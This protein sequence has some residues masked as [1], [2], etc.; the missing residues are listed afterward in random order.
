MRR[1]FGSASF[2]F[3]LGLSLLLLAGCGGSA[4]TRSGGSAA[5]GGKGPVTLTFGTWGGAAEDQQLQAL[6]RQVNEEHKGEFQIVEQNTPANYDDKLKTQLAGGTAPD[7]FYVSDGLVETFAREG[8]LLDLTPYLEKYKSRYVEADLSAYYPASL[9]HVKVGGKVYALPWVAQPVVMYYN[10]ELFRQAGLPEPQ[11]GWTWDQF[12]QDAKKLTDPARNQYGYIQANGWPPVEMYLWAYGGD[13][14]DPSLSRSTIDS[15]QALKGLQLMERMVK[16]GVTPPLS[17][18]ANVD[19]ED[20][21]RQGRVAMFAG[22]AADGNYQTHGFTAK[23]AELPRGTQPASFLYVADM[24]INAKAKDPDLAFRAMMALLEKIDHWKVLPPI[25]TYA[26]DLQSIQVPDAPGGHTPAD[27]V[28]PIL[29]SMEYARTPQQ[30]RDMTDYY[31]I[32]ANDIY[33]PILS[34]R[35]SAEAAARKAAR[36]LDAIL[37]Q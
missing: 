17:Q 18:L 12:L 24:A 30:I 22:G 23:V 16:E 6:I 36:D 1:R 5:S 21:F 2:A 4:P 20:L 25:K 33:Q 10:P 32:L 19:I 29:D 35:S 28:R 34:G 15:P 8:A 9:V 27:R 7:I 3:L 11:P 13:M 31:N 26:A 37:K 14:F